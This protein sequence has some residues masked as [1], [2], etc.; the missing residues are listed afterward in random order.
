M[1]QL[2]NL[3]YS[4]SYRNASIY[5]GFSTHPSMEKSGTEYGWRREWDSNPRYGRQDFGPSSD[6]LFRNDW[7]S[8]L[9]GALLCRL[10]CDRGAPRDRALP[11]GLLGGAEVVRR[12]GSHHLR[13]S[14]DQN[15]N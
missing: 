2:S 7:L 12:M 15:Q 3:K 10:G 8:S 1:P 6:Y 13:G 11:G 14:H 5:W 4:C 9:I